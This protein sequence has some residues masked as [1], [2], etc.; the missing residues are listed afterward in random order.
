MTADSFNAENTSDSGKPDVSKSDAGEKGADNINAGELKNAGEWSAENNLIFGAEL[1]RNADESLRREWLATNGLGGYASASLATANT[2]RYHGLLVAALNPPVGRAVLLSKLEETLTVTD[3]QGSNT[4]YA[5]SANVY[6]GAIYPQGYQYL[7]AW[8]A[9]P[10]P[11]WIWQPAPGLRFEKRVWMA[12]GENTTYIAYRL[13]NAPENTAVRLSLIPLLAWRDYHSEMAAG[14]FHPSATWLSSESASELQL[15]LPP[16]AR[17]TSVPTTLSLRLLAADSQPVPAAHFEPHSDWYYHIQH[18]RE[19]ERG[20]D[21]QEDLYAPGTLSLPLTPGQTI[22]VAASA[23]EQG[24]GNREQGTEGNAERGMMNDEL[25]AHS[26][27]ITH[28][29]SFPNTQHPTPNTLLQQLALAADQFI[30]QVPGVRSTIIAG[31]PWFGDWGRDTMISLPG[32]CLT[33]GKMDIAREILLS[34]ARYVDA[35]ML[36][37]RFPDVGETPEYNTVDATLWYFVAIY[38]YVEATG[39]VGL[40]SSGLWET[41]K[42]IVHWHQQGTRYNIHVDVNDSLLYA[43][44]DGVQLTWMDAKVGDWVVTPR[45]GK[46]VEINALWVNALRVMAHFANLLNDSSGNS[47]T[48]Q[49]QQTQASFLSRFAREDGRGLYD[50]LDDAEGT[51]NREQGTGGADSSFILHPSSLSVRP[52]QIFALSL[53]FP[54]VEPSSALATAI[55]KVV[56]EELLTPC[57]LRT[58]SPHDPD[59]KPRYEG[60][61]WHRDGAYH[62]GTVWPWLLGPFAEAYAKVTGDVEGAKQMLSGLQAQL[63]TFG[64]GSLAEIFDGAEPHRPNGCYAQAWSIAETLRVWQLLCSQETQV[65]ESEKDI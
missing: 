29:S 56:R 25:E 24:T 16:I 55:I 3:A 11:T 58:L 6:P 49:A 44:Q 22:V 2:R 20:Q 59:F 12:Q 43:G 27:L 36:P 17:V 19:Q 31:Y 50:V 34:F 54:I 41:L 60:D 1:L 51:G 62:Q 10:T 38:R 52:N 33:T 28:H 13:L 57:G 65:P 23:E 8:S 40:L 21:F 9:Y 5:L 63:T 18:P 32:L 30:V 26:S 14:D 64:I 45:I 46:P 4:A 35:G 7:E 53:P 37:N 48:Q 61:A 47:Y 42:Q 15:L 39:D